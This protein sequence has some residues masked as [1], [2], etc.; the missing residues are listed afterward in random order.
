MRY[1]YCDIEAIGLRPHKGVVW[2]FAYSYDGKKLLLLQ[3]CYGLKRASFPKQLIADLESEEVCKVF[4]N[5]IYDGAYVEC[6]LGIRMRNVWCTMATEKKILGYHYG[7]KELKT[8]TDPM[9][10][11]WSVAY[12]HVLKRYGLPVPDKTVRENFIDRPLGKKFDKR[13]L[14]YML[15]DIRPLRALQKAQEYL[16][17]RDEMMEIVLLENKVVEKIAHMRAVGI[18]FDSKIWQKVYTE[19]L[20][21]HERRLAIMPKAVRNWNSEQQVKAYFR[22]IGIHITSYEDLDQVYLQ[23]RNRTLG[24]FIATRELQKSVGTYG[25]N[26]FEDGL[27]DDDDRVRCDVTPS[28]STGRMSMANPNLQQL[29]GEGNNDPVRLTVLKEI[30]GGKLKPKH[31]LAFVP[32]KGHVFVIGDFSGQ[33][34]GIMAAAGDEKIWQ[35]AL[36]RGDDVHSLTAS[37]LFP[38]DWESG[39]TRACSFPSKCK[40][41]EHKIKRSQTK[42]LNFMLAYGGGPQKFSESTNTDMFNSKLIVKRYKRVVQKLTNWLEHNA[43]EALDTGVS[44]SADPYRSRR[45]LDGE[46]AWQIENKGKNNPIQSAGA[47]ML[48]LAMISL[49]DNLEIVLVIHDEII[50]EV[51]TGQA[52]KACKILK[53][54]MEQS[55]DYITGIR[56]L[57]KVEPRVAMNIMKEE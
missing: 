29:P 45:V 32:R 25:I 10:A 16:A 43:K 53:T 30:T 3:D 19:N 36:L 38:L 56:G 52:K 20:K 8:K 11:R 34:I 1:L 13:E 48:K 57:I 15:D 9:A 26:W 6:V 27:V 49:P 4:H 50:L 2:S 22:S 18:G 23:T 33:E 31:R 51:S 17:K 42:V 46:E 47:N 40:C 7:R 28:V 35:D 44:F 12:K 37:L 5:F 54:I 39:R 21:E 55:A 14:G 41:P 24:D